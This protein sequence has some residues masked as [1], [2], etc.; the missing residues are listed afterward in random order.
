MYMCNYRLGRN[1]KLFMLE[2]P[3]SCYGNQMAEL[4]DCSIQVTLQHQ[5]F[6]RELYMYMYGLCMEATD[7][8]CTVEQAS[9]G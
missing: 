3:Y 9:T 6:Q 7:Y 1:A 4:P 5:K 8:T 2:Q